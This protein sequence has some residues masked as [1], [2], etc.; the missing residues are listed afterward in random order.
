MKM[1]SETYANP[2]CKHLSKASYYYPQPKKSSLN[3][4]LNILPQALHIVSLNCTAFPFSTLHLHLH[5]RLHSR[6]HLLHATELKYSIKEPSALPQN[7]ILC[8]HH[9]VNDTHWDGMHICTG[10]T[11]Q[12]AILG[13]G[14]FVYHSYSNQE[15]A[16]N[17]LTEINKLSYCNLG[18]VS[19][20]KL[21]C[22]LTLQS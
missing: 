12:V 19:I 3:G 10:S 2:S 5:L 20:P 15:E 18:L 6:N 13:Y 16:G 7:M 17:L 9:T 1:N 14:L 21:K 4:Y 22:F 8:C 11:W